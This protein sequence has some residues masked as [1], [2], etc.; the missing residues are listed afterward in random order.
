MMYEDYAKIVATQK[1]YRARPHEYPW[2]DRKNGHKYFRY[3]KDRVILFYYGQQ[4][5]TVHPN[6][7]IEFAKDYMY[8]GDRGQLSILLPRGEITHSE[9]QGGLVWTWWDSNDVRSAYHVRE[10][11]KFDL[12]TCKPCKEFYYDLIH[13]KFDNKKSAQ[14]RKKYKD[15]LVLANQWL[16]NSD[17]DQIMDDLNNCKGCNMEEF[18]DSLKT[19]SPYELAIMSYHISG[20]VFNPTLRLSRI[21]RNYII[22]KCLK[23]LRYNLYNLEDAA[24]TSTVSWKEGVIKHNRPQIIFINNPTFNV[25]T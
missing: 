1:H 24:V 17:S 3:V 2:S 16:H 22:T 13:T 19:K 21:E 9:S 11:M 23:N 7:T 18:K 25:S 14:V 5:A 8:Q 15:I 20:G 12:K 4:L 6:N 10:G